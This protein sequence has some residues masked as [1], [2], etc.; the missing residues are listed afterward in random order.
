MKTEFLRAALCAVAALVAVCVS[1]GAQAQD[2]QLASTAEMHNVYA[3]L[4]ELESRLAASNGGV[5]CTDGVKGCGDSCCDNDCCRSG[6]IA[7]GEVLFLKPFGGDDDWVNFDTFEDGF[8]FWIGYQR[9]DGLGIRARLFDFEQTAGDDYIDI[10]TFDLEIY[11]SFQ[12]SCNWDLV[13]GG[14]IRYLDYHD[15]EDDGD[16]DAITGVGPVVTAELYRH[17]NDRLALYAIGRQSI[18]VGNGV[19][20]GNDTE[21]M[22]TSITELQLGAQVHREWN[23][24]YLFGRAGWEAQT[25][26]DVHDDAEESTTLMGAVFSAG[27]LR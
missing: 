7:G 22:A 9:D 26:N 16:N 5:G 10:T 25:F 15:D 20:E 17:V 6:W 12:L 2:I 24:A 27:I 18:V 1:G 11:D 23:G 8:R 3:R 19:A 14:G 21:D 13:L 4:A